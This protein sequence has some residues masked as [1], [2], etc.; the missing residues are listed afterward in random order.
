[1]TNPNLEPTPNPVVC[2]HPY[3]TNVAMEEHYRTRAVNAAYWMT[4]SP[5][6]RSWTQEQQQLMAAYC[7]WAHQRLCAIEQLSGGRDLPRIDY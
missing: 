7:L 1:M 4:A 3:Q 2:L 5:H 6:E